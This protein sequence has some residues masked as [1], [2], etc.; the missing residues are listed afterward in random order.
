MKSSITVFI[1]QEKLYE[2]SP[3]LV[4]PF[5]ILIYGTLY[6]FLIGILSNIFLCKYTQN[7]LKKCFIV[8]YSFKKEPLTLPT[9]LLN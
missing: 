7:I 9:V 8:E 1:L 4:A 3:Y 5:D 6:R 2:C